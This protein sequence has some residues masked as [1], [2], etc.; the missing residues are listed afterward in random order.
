MICRKPYV[1]SSICFR[2]TIFQ[3]P[4]GTLWTYGIMSWCST[5]GTEERAHD[6]T[7]S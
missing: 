3:N 7:D 1:V 4:E 2:A 6:K 5:Y